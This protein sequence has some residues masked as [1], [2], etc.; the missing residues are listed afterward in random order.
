MQRLKRAQNLSLI[1]PWVTLSVSDLACPTATYS[2]LSVRVWPVSASARSKGECKGPLC[3]KQL[4]GPGCWTSQV[5]NQ[6]LPLTEAIATL[7]VLKPL[8]VGS[9][10][11]TVLHLWLFRFPAQSAQNL[12]KNKCHTF[13]SFFLNTYIAAAFSSL[14]AHWGVRCSPTWRTRSARPPGRQEKSAAVATPKWESDGLW[15]AASVSLPTEGWEL[16]ELHRVWASETLPEHSRW[17]CVLQTSVAPWKQQPSAFI[18]VFCSSSCS[19][20][21]L[22][23]FISGSWK[24]TEA[25]LSIHFFFLLWLLRLRVWRPEYYKHVISFNRMERMCSL[26]FGSAALQNYYW[27]NNSPTVSRNSTHISLFTVC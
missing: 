13:L 11:H 4:W 19:S 10:H 24:P 27:R 26:I 17:T 12:A 6:C 5:R 3:Q 7:A 22:V 9:G 14:A 1:Y 21:R 23:T 16:K 18:L 8:H 15:S 20:I 25:R 2:F